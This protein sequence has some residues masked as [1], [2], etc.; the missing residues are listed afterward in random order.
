MIFFRS[1]RFYI[2]KAEGVLVQ[3]EL[4]FAQIH[5]LCFLHSHQKIS[6]LKK[7]KSYFSFF[8]KRLVYLFVYSLTKE[9]SWQEWKCLCFMTFSASDNK[10]EKWK[11]YFEPINPLEPGGTHPLQSL[12]F[13]VLAFYCD[14]TYHI[15]Q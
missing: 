1:K 9:D 8:Y 15:Y 7:K 14:Y 4:E 13:Q 12:I 10:R 6:Q 5:G 3:N 2:H 11:A